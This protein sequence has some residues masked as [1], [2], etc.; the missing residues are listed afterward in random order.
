MVTTPRVANAANACCS[1]ISVKSS[2]KTPCLRQCLE[3]K[4]STAPA[5]QKL[6][7]SI[8]RVREHGEFSVGLNH[9]VD[10]LCGADNEKIRRWGYDQLGTYNI[11][12]EFGR[13]EWKAIAREL[14]RPGQPH[15]TPGQMSVLELTDAGLQWLRNRD[16]PPL[17]LT[18]L[19]RPSPRKARAH[20]RPVPANWPAT[21]PTDQLRTLPRLASDGV[22]PYIIFGDVALR[23]AARECLHPC[24]IRPHPR[25]RRKL[26]ECGDYSRKPSPPV[27]DKPKAGIRELRAI[28]TY[29]F[30]L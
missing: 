8:Y 7:A 26:N 23:H 28:K 12:N 5:A 4:P 14:V 22:P 27:G 10:V 9:I 13:D 19:P 2:R 1:V 21:N 3:P 15:Q 29:L 6:L 16:R 11:G 25:S 18:R 17:E 30:P 24:R 20:A